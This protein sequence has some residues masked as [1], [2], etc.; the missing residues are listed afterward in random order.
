MYHYTEG[1]DSVGFQAQ[2]ITEGPTFE[3]VQKLKRAGVPLHFTYMSTLEAP[4]PLRLGK[5][6][7]GARRKTGF[8]DHCYR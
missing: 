2:Y 3:T 6:H 1:A 8:G 4:P 5:A 7:H